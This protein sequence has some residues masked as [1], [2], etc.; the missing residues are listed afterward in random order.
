MLDNAFNLNAE[1]SSI[2]H[3]LVQL[4]TSN[5]THV[6]SFYRI[7]LQI[8]SLL[9]AILELVGQVN[10]N[11]AGVSKQSIYVHVR[12]PTQPVSKD[13]PVAYSMSLSVTCFCY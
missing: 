2:T 5:V 3:L 11:C 12:K 10:T 9:R 13:T 4:L 6:S 7:V 8:Y 1:M